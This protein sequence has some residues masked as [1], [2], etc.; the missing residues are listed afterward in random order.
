MNILLTGGAGYIGSHIAVEL[1]HA[2][3]HVIVVD[4]LCN[5]DAKSL[6]RV[7]EITNREPLFFQTDIR[8]EADLRQIFAAN[9]IEACIHC[10]GLKAVGESTQKPLEYYDNNIGGTLTLLKIMHKYNCKNLVFSSSATVYGAADTLPITETTPQKPC[11]NPYGWTKSMIEQILTDIQH[12]APEWNIILLRYFNPIGAHP[13]GKIGENPNGT[14]NNLMPYITQ[15]AVGKRPQL[16]V[17]GNDY[18]TPDGTG[19]RD[20]I[21]VVDLA[22][23]HLKA[24]EALS[25][26]C[27]LQIY[28]LSTGNGY[29]VLDIVKTFE[30]VNGIAVP[31]KIEPRRPGDIAACYASADK[32]ARELGWRAELGLDDMCRDAWN[33]QKSNPDGF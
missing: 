8:N 22:K 26:N 23:G 31:Y 33:W 29:S 5:A 2:G 12:A 30:R 19:I 10:A 25:R 9:R 21:H 15:V 18:A 32:A 20:Y 1:L 28:N 11:T 27:G 3:H 4:N 6:R 7:A 13:S 16:N 17:Y 24:L 14:P